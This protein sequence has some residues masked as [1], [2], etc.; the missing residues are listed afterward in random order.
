MPDIGEGEEGNKLHCHGCTYAT[1]ILALL[2][3]LECGDVILAHCN[4]CLLGSSDS[5]ASASRVVGITGGHHHTWLTFAFLVKTETGPCSVI[6]ARVQWHNHSSLQPRTPGLKQSSHLS[7]PKCWDYKHV[8]LSP[9]QSLVLLPRLEYSGTILAYCNLCLPGSSNSP[10]SASQVA[11]I[12]GTH[13]HAR[14]ILV[15]SVE[16]G[17]H[18]VGQASLEQ[19]TSESRSVTQAGV[20]CCDFSS[21]QHLPPG[22]KRLSCLSLLSSWDYRHMPPCSAN[23]LFLVETGFHPVIGQAGFKLLTSG[24]PPT[25]DSQSVEI[26][27]VSLCCGQTSFQSYIGIVMAHEM[28]SH[29]IVQSGLELLD[30]S[31][32]L[33]SASQSAVITGMS[34]CTWPPLLSYLILRAISILW[35]LSLSP[36]LEYSGA[37]SAHCNLRLP[38]SSD[39]PASASRIAG[40]TESFSVARLECSGVILAH[41]NLCPR[42]SSYSPVS[43]SRVAGTTGVSHCARPVLYCLRILEH[44]LCSCSPAKS[45]SIVT[46]FSQRNRTTVSI[47]GIKPFTAVGRAGEV[48]VW[49]EESE[50][51]RVTSRCRKHWC[52]WTNQS[53]QENSRNQST[54]SHRSGAAEGEFVERFMGSCGLYVAPAPC[55][56]TAKLGDS[57]ASASEVAGITSVCHCA[58][59]IFVF[60]VETG[61]CHFGQAGLKLLTS[62]DPPASASQSAGITG[63]S[64]CAPPNSFISRNIL[65][66]GKCLSLILSPRLE[67]SGAILAHC[68]L[69]L[70]GWSDPPALASRVAGAT[71]TCHHALL[72]FVFLV[73]MGFDHVGQPGLELLSC[74]HPPVS[75]SQ[76]AGITELCSGAILAHCSFDLLGSGDPPTPASRVAGNTDTCHCTWPCI[77]FHSCCPGWSVMVRSWLTATS[78]SWVQAILPQPPCPANFVLLVETGF[79][80]AGL[81][82]LE[83]PTSQVIPSPRQIPKCWDYRHEPPRLTQS[84]SP[85]LEYSGA[86]LA[87]CNLRLLG[88]SDF[89]VSASQVAEITD[90][91]HHARTESCSVAQAGVQCTISAHYNLCLLGS[92]NYPVSASQV[93]GTTGAHHHAWLIFV[94]LVETGFHHI[95]QADLELLTSGDPPALASQSAGITVEVG[96]HH[97]GQDGLRL[98]SYP[99]TSDSQ[100]SGITGV[101]HPAWPIIYLFIF[102]TGSDCVT[103][104][105]VQW[106]YLGSLQPLPPRHKGF[107]CLSLLHSWDYRRTLW[108]ATCLIFVLLTSK[109]C[110][111]LAE[112]TLQC[113]EDKWIGAL[114]GECTLQRDKHAGCL[115]GH[116]VQELR[117]GQVQ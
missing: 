34:H 40:I 95:G 114:I 108:P 60:L 23:F 29:Y 92:S 49:K 13:H 71:G 44:W 87:H 63:V 41:C 45:I 17:F 1:I 81:A 66:L 50:D 14:L 79:L 19:L 62:G 113:G 104:A 96:F 80:H 22:F 106:C 111:R 97:V 37:I 46:G 24:D 100:S 76:S 75:A 31:D 67:G 91:C 73:E 89:P 116:I 15:F 117:T 21:L 38:D 101:S 98:L 32:P 20:Q 30:S 27:G 47:L 84:L 26:A 61:F 70:P 5:C 35:S 115:F 16:K 112:F 3:R 109:D 43:A 7:L 10:A 18:H 107:S 68:N 86:I 28:R 52:S 102:E 99:P 58:Q 33:A 36:R 82:G 56:A 53:L 74:R 57:P 11:G 103:Q 78:A 12:I 48:N 94:F 39:S 42:G 69:H 54:S 90:G 2:P 6:Q 88:S 65:Q 8:P 93:A 4:L 25:S 110:R 85:G 77:E 72:T 64:H 9:R 55:G 83:L 59:L 51:Q 105:A